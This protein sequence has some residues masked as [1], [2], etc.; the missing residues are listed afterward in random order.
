MSL[1]AFYCCKSEK[2][3]PS[4][5]A[6]ATTQ[7]TSL[8]GK[9]KSDMDSDEKSHPLSLAEKSITLP[10]FW[11]ICSDDASFYADSAMKYQKN[12]SLKMGDSVFVDQV[13]IAA[14]DPIGDRSFNLV[15]P[16]SIYHIRFSA[17]NGRGEAYVRGRFLADA[18]RTDM[19]G[20]GNNEM[21]AARYLALSEEEFGFENPAEI[22]LIKSGKI[23]SFLAFKGYDEFT[24]KEC[25]ET[26]FYPSLKCYEMDQQ[27]G[28]CDYPHIE[29][30][31]GIQGE[32]LLPIL[33]E[34]ST[35]NEEGGY[36][37]DYIFPN[38]SGGS[39]NQLKVITHLM[40]NE[41]KVDHK[42]YYAYKYTNGK[43]SGGKV[44]KWH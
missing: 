5:S 35:G 37:N 17:S 39:P 25:P 13:S 12:L 32:K 23:I 21:I 24:I 36:W 41:E 7:S 42:T 26:G 20:D 30:F 2:S 15:N 18:V 22:L 27:Y 4:V 14:G 8:A 33:S 43:F 40:N 29:I 11:I 44:H 9:G 10:S 6:P 16:D 34:S 1:A 31:F 3:T 28:A 19:D 38:D